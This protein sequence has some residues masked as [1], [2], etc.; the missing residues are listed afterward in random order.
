MLGAW[1]AGPSGVDSGHHA[2]FAHVH[3]ALRGGQAPPVATAESLRTLRLVA[4]I[5][6]SAF[7]EHTVRPEDLGPGSPFFERMDGAEPAWGPP[8]KASE[9]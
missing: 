7:E 5:Y 4:G 8:G 6:A 1:R 3:R 9:R 2:Q